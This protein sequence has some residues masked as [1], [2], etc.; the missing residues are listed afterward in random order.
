MVTMAS[1]SKSTP[2]KRN[3]ILQLKSHNSKDGND[4]Y[5][6]TEEWLSKKWG[7]PGIATSLEN[8]E[9]QNT[10]TPFENGDIQNNQT[11]NENPPNILNPNN[12]NPPRTSNSQETNQTTRRTKTTSLTD[13][14]KEGTPNKSCGDDFTTTEHHGIRIWSNNVN[15]LQTA[16]DYS[17]FHEL[18]ATLAEHKVNVIAL[19]EINLDTTKQKVRKKLLKVMKFHFKQVRM[20]ACSTPLRNHKDS[21]WKPGGVLLAVVGDLARKV[22]S[23]SIDPLGRWCEI[24]LNRRDGG[25]VKIITAYQCVD[26]TLQSSGHQTYFFQLHKLLREKKD[27]IDIDPRKEFIADLKQHLMKDE[28]DLTSIILTGDFNETIGEKPEM[29]ASICAEIGLLDIVS[30]LHPDALGTPTYDRGR[31]RLDYILV[32]DDLP[33]F[34]LQSGMN[35][36]NEIHN[37]DH[38]AQWVDFHKRG[39]MAKSSPVPPSNLRGVHS[40][41]ESV[42]EFVNLT[43]KLLEEHKV[44]ERHDK[45]QHNIEETHPRTRK[46]KR[47]AT[48][49]NNIDAQMTKAMLAAEKKVSKPRR[50]GWSEEVHQASKKV[51]LWATIRSGRRQKMD[52]SETLR[53]LK[54]DHGIT[55]VIPKT[56]GEIEKRLEAA[57]RE[58]RLK[59]RHGERKRKEFAQIL[60]E[61]IALRKTRTKNPEAALRCIEKQLHSNDTWSHIKMALKKDHHQALTKIE[62]T[63][64]EDGETVTQT[65]DKR[66]DLERKI[67]ERN[68][69]HFAQAV[70]TPWTKEP[71]KSSSIQNDYNINSIDIE[72]LPEDT[73]DETK[74]LID[75]SDCIKT[76]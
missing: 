16:N 40:N 39:T 58:V 12:E 13:R 73:L 9:H 51:R 5:S 33:Q 49:A 38:R 17:Q 54:D 69:K 14:L 50:F 47:I 55:A 75:G 31:K 35:R 62:V 20:I 66:A 42:E 2:E 65:F 76:K 72:E 7:E 11:H 63:T 37:T 48:E 34:A 59:R 67:L 56:L 22:A 43:Y 74:E 64:K 28:R 27:K 46:K 32:S 52:V 45:L 6:N 30:K 61:R 23:S 70:G 36:F 15:T 41:S 44:I 19:Q 8:G 24:N 1:T 60:K 21:D 4:E 57:R 71:L 68:Q 10:L 26:T 3:R 18:C 29:M 53:K 25:I